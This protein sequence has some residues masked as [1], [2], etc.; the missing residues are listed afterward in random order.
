MEWMLARD[1]FHS[2]SRLDAADARHVLIFQKKLYE[3][4]DCTL[5]GFNFEALRGVQDR[6]VKSLRVDGSIRAIVWHDG[7][8][9]VLLY[10]A[11]HVPAYRWAESVKVNVTTLAHC[12]AVAV[13]MDA[14][15]P[16]G[17]EQQWLR[18]GA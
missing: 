18:P 1:W 6:R 4:P 12:V 9:G 17:Y 16:G 3:D 15:V 5:P 10:V 13:T 14:D 7:P 11:Q 8:L 2:A